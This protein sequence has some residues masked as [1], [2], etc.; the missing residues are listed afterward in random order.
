MAIFQVKTKNQSDIGKKP[1]VYFTCHPEDFKLYF[2]KVCEDIFL[3][4]DCAI[5]YTEDMR[6]PIAED[7][8]EVDLGRNNLF[9]VANIRSLGLGIDIRSGGDHAEHNDG[10]HGKDQ[11]CSHGF[12]EGF[13]CLAAKASEDLI[14]SHSPPFSM[15]GSS[16]RMMVVVVVTPFTVT[17]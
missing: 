4:H 12:D 10:A 14:H 2:K 11:D 15:T 5:Y 17:S 13:A 9:V 8:K 3:T 6:A 1:R 16:Q 7:E